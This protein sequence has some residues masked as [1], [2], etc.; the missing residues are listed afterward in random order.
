[1]LRAVLLGVLAIPGSA[2][3]QA[4]PTM[5]GPVGWT[6]VIAATINIV[7]VMAAVKAI[8]LWLPALRER[9]PMLVPLLAMA[10]GPALAW[11]QGVLAAWLGL[12]IDLSP[13]VGALS[14]GSAVAVHQIY[15]QHQRVLKTGGTLVALTK[16]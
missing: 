7:G 2:W 5:P 13:I 1:M 16:L 10:A 9:S 12:P 14:G 4:G 11:G 3:A 8:T 15:N 6:D